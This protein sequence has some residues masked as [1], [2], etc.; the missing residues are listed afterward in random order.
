[1]P[2]I[3]HIVMWRLNGATADAKNQQAADIV[4]AFEQTR[5]SIPGLLRMEVG[6]NIHDGQDDWDIALYMAF[7]SRQHL[8][9]YQSHPAHLA[10]KQLV[11]PMRLSR[12]QVDFQ[13]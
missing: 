10:I 4:E 13:L 5:D 3:V 9:G 6:R 7:E 1:M 2:E 11:G 12:G 8:E